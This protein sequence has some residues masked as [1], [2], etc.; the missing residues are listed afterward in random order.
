MGD[1]LIEHFHEA[2]IRRHK[3]TDF[4]I[5]IPFRTVSALGATCKDRDSGVHD[6][7]RR[8]EEKSA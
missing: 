1:Q 6:A 4:D 2:S 7:I 3:K 5:A 8:G